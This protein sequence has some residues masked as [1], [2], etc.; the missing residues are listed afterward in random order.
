MKEQLMKAFKNQQIVQMIY[1]AKDGTIT[2][3]K[4]KIVKLFGDKVQA[5]CFTRNAK[6]TFIIDHILAILPTSKYERKVV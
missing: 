3:R 2:K 6:R 1:V 5:Y 4:V